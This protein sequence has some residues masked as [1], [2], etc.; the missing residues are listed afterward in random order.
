MV[1][2]K[3]IEI[4]FQLGVL[5]DKLIRGN[6]EGLVASSPIVQQVSA[7]VKLIKHSPFGLSTK[8]KFSKHHSNLP[9]TMIKPMFFDPFTETTERLY[10]LLGQL[11]LKKRKILLIYIQWKSVRQIMKRLNSLRQQIKGRKRYGN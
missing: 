10:I 8:T 1:V 5:V 2:V 9:I 4:H 3:I 6:I 11:A 7:S